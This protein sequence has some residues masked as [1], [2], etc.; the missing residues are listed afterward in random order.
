MGSGGNLRSIFHLLARLGIP[1]RLCNRRLVRV[2]PCKSAQGS[3]KDALGNTC[4]DC[5]CAQHLLAL[6]CS[7]TGSAVAD[8]SGKLPCGDENLILAEYIQHKG[9]YIILFHVVLCVTC[10]V[11]F[12]NQP[13]NPYVLIANIRC[14]NDRTIF[15][16]QYTM[17]R[18]MH[19]FLLLFVAT[20]HVSTPRHH[21]RRQR[22]SLAFRRSL[23]GSVMY[24]SAFVYT[25]KGAPGWGAPF[26]KVWMNCLFLDHL[27]GCDAAVFESY[28]V[29]VEAFCKRLDIYFFSLCVS[30]LCATH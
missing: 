9:K 3:R 2:S 5:D 7:D 12:F 30:N 28:A 20:A 6:V 22:I 23:F 13:H 15:A 11:Y 25:K 14:N 29:Y 26:G 16:Q 24:T 10:R 4:T 17:H 18:I 27:A 19:H 1:H 8:G 21:H